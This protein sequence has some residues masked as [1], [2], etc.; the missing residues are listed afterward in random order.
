[1]VKLEVTTICRLLQC[2]SR[3]WKSEQNTVIV[4]KVSLIQDNLV[5]KE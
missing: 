4:G 1:V 5:I 3:E 2:F